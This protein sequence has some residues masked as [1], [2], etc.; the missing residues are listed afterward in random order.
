MVMFAILLGCINGGLDDAVGHTN[1]QNG[2]CI[3]ETTHKNRMAHIP[4][5]FKIKGKHN[6]SSCPLEPYVA[7]GPALL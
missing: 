1:T 7:G 5:P 2:Q 4:D 3:P 6:L